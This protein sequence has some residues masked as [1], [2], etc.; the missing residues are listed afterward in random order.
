MEV[1]RSLFSKIFNV[2]SQRLPIPLQI[3]K[4]FRSI[5][6]TRVVMLHQLLL[7]DSPALLNTLPPE[8]AEGF[9][10]LGAVFG[11]VGEV[12]GG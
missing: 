1:E 8:D 6:C 5:R 11:V 12:F 3:Y 10:A 7:L 2:P 4:W 9:V